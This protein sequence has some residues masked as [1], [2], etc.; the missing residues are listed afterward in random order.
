MAK[1]LRTF[2]AYLDERYPKEIVRVS[3]PVDPAWEIAAVVRKFQQENR[4]PTLL[5]ENVAGFSMPVVTN[6]FASRVKLAAALET[7]PEETLD[8]YM[9]RED[10]PLEPR[11]VDGGPV[12]ECR[13]LG[14][15][16]DLSRL[17]IVTHGEKD[18]GPYITP[19]IGIAKDPDSG[20]HNA[21]VYRLQYRGPREMGIDIGPDSHLAHILRKRERKGEDLEF[22][23]ALGHHPAVCHGSQ[24][25]GPLEMDEFA[26]MGGLL[27]EPLE[28]VRGETV[29][30]GVPARAE[31]VI[32][33]RILAGVREVEGPFG[34]FTWH[35]GPARPNPVFR[36]TAITHRRDA[37]F[38]DLNNLYLDHNFL[39]LLGRESNLYKRV[40]EV[41]PSL[42]RVAVA[43][44]GGCRLSGFVQIH[45]EY[46]GQGKNAAL[47]ALAADPYMKVVVVVDEDVD[48][49]SDR[50]V[51]WAVTT[52]TQPDRDFFFVPG[53]FV[54]I[55]DPSGHTGVS[56]AEH[57]GM[58]T[59]VAIDAT[60]P[61]EV[62]FPERCDVRRDLWEGID[63]GEYVSS[64]AGVGSPHGRG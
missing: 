18:A 47:A 23:V 36:V 55:I 59:R 56:R 14:A 53:T 43:E 42:R 13:R 63:L 21:G 50:E 10:R 54:C 58:N 34:E 60:K 26:V 2:I 38:L 51:L 6:L 3:R 12:K 1:D 52:R 20:V 22:A 39:G 17:P 48:V 64:P 45:K 28:L 16:A 7:S 27:G 4:F 49:Y 29:D 25:R 30:L 37:I 35:Y 33:G 31:I 11:W 57:G 24:A 8:E 19:G 32:E 40:R 61:V 41:I 46:E 44:S 5:F 9:R 62:P 15:E